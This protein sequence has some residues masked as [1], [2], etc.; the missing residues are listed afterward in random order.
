VIIV[1]TSHGAEMVVDHLGVSRSRVVVVPS[2]VDHA[3]FSAPPAGTAREPFLLYPANAWP[4]KNHGV[5]FEAFALLRRER[6]EL[7]LVLTGA[8][9][10]PAAAPPGVEVRGYVTQEELVELY[11]R[12][13]AMVFP[14]L[15]EGFGQPLLEAMACGCPVAASGVSSI[16]EVCGGAARLFDPTSAEAVADAVA[17]V[18]R[19]GETWAA[20]GLEHAAGFSWE[21]TARATEAVY[22]G[23]A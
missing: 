6:P 9:H 8:G 11:R 7:R 5:L 16:P 10:D 17:D 22:R 12:A 23:L 19:S 20:L 4:H 13:A 14:S 1:F 21:R 2:G 18:L 3:R 15:Y